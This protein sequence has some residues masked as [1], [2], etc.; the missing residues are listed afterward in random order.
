MLYSKLK[1]LGLFIALLSSQ[2]IIAQTA[3]MFTMEEA[4]LMI[5]KNT[6]QSLRAKSLSQLQWL[7]SGNKYS[8]VINGAGARIVLTEAENGKVDSTITL[9]VLNEAIKVLDPKLSLKSIPVFQW[10]DNENFRIKQGAKYLSFNISSQS[11]RELFATNEKAE[12]EEI[13]STKGYIAFVLND[14]IYITTGSGIKQITTDGGKGIVYGQ[15][16]HRNEFGITKGLFWSPKG[17]KLAFYRMDESMVTDYSIYDNSTVPA[18][19]TNIKYPTAGAK[20]HHVTIGVYDLNTERLNYLETG[21]P[22]EQYLTNVTWSPDEET[23]Y[24]AIVNRGQNQMFLNRYNALH[25]HIELSLFEE[26]DEKY[27]EPQHPLYFIPGS[28]DRFIWQSERDGYNH[29]YLY[30]NEGQLIRQLTQGKWM[31]TNLLGTDADGETVFF[32]STKESPLERHTYSVELNGTN[33][34]KLT[35]EQGTNA[36]FVNKR[37]TYIL[38]YLNSTTVARKI[39]LINTKNENASK[40]LLDAPNPLAD[41]KLGETTLFPIVSNGTV[42]H[43]RMITPPDFDKTKQYPVIV[44]V[45][46]GPHAQMVTNSWLGGSNGWMQ[47]MAQ[48]GYIVFT[49]D[50]RG[51]SN[52]GHEFESA[53]HRQLGTLEMEDQLAG[54]NYLKNLS[55]VNPDRMAVH[56]WSFGGFMTTSMMTRMPGIFQVGV[57]GGPVIDWK[58]YEIMYTER[59][60]DTPEENP[61]GYAKANLIKYVDNLE[62]KLLMIHGCDDDVVLW[63]HSLLY[64]KAAVD[65]VNTNLD[66]FVYPGHK[67]NVAGKDRV[68]LMQKITD[69]I[70]ENL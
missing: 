45:Y 37:G 68:H 13:E 19:T 50:N 48:Q 24:V 21:E 54:I 23:I 59:Y 47:L 11:F 33:F 44:Y 63:Q 56:G 55:Y 52:R 41:F 53:T 70:M 27:I 1:V 42:L 35:T 39:T 28:P 51:S 18:S 3:R 34:K 69:Y 36:S 8:Y 14:N 25:G 16:V 12:F 9:N 38:N 30:S 62:S 46:G 20:S 6:K 43:C 15:S 7:P 60:M 65:N 5:D 29:L 26:R 4:V 22:K 64:C 67:H 49:L 10:L 17:N 61:E 58:L 31:V 2:F 66:Y 57:A 32:E 40:L